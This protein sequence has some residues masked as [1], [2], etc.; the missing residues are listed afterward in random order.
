V[1]TGWKT[2]LLS[3]GARPE[4]RPVA[5]GQSCRSSTTGIEQRNLCTS[6]P[7]ANSEQRVR[8]REHS[9][10]TSLTAMTNVP[11]EKQAG[12]MLVHDKGRLA[13]PAPRRTNHPTRRAK[14][15]GFCAGL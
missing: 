7:Q 15:K 12:F 3:Q 10:P 11:T 4:L 6:A 8:H 9:H 13:H 1:T 2:P 14:V 5:F